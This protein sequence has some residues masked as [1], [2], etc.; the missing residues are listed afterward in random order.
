MQ[1]IEVE[2]QDVAVR[3]KTEEN[4]EHRQSAVPATPQQHGTGTDQKHFDRYEE[5]GIGAEQQLH[6]RIGFT[7]TTGFDPDNGKNAI[8]C[9]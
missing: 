6:K 4:R 7:E 8:N 2:S 1:S 3:A 9:V 5:D